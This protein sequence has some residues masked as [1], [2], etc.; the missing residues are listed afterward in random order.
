MGP[1]T[2]HGAA[3]TLR[4]EERARRTECARQCTA[5]G[6]CSFLP[7][8]EPP[9]RAAPDGVPGTGLIQVNIRRWSRGVP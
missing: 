8:R 4:A 6:G 2:P 5:G 1:C 7:A 9:G 3:R